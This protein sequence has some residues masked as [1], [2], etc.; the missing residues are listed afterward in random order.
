MNKDRKA[1]LEKICAAVNSGKFGGSNKDAI[2]YLGAT[3]TVELVR[4]GSGCPML[5]NVLGGSTDNKGYPVGRFVEVYGS[6]S[7]GKTT[8]I[9]H[10]IAEFQKKWPEKDVAFV[11][12][13]F[14][15]DE[16]YA[17]SIGV[18]TDYLLVHQ[19]ETADQA[20][21]IIKQLAELGIK[22]IVVDSVAALSPK[23]EQDNDLGDATVALQARKMSSSLR[24]LTSVCGKNGV[25]VIFTNQLRENIGVTYGDKTITPAGRALK[26]YASIR[27]SIVRTGSEKQTINGEKI[28]IS[29]NVKVN[30]K[31]NKTAPPFKVARFTITYG[32]GIDLEAAYLDTALAQGVVTKRGGWHTFNGENIANGRI[33]VL[34]ILRQDKNL[35][36]SI[37]GRLQQSNEI[38]EN[39]EKLRKA[40]VISDDDV[41]EVKTAMETIKE[42]VVE[43]PKKRGRPKKS[44]KEKMAEIRRKAVTQKDLDDAGVIVED[45]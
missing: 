1:R 6:E 5:D 10:A 17:Q 29:N 2:Q 45:V 38:E 25:T 33:N 28:N 35:M 23:E 20:L 22:L 42:E 18:N 21:N 14:A 13:E 36:D 11:D 19:P 12:S 15:F 16:L 30:I 32:Y 27:L 40:E 44:A 41:V 3:E 4:F 26:H 34:D 43:A 9:L 7:A 24:Q 8:L 37:V 39:L 31:K